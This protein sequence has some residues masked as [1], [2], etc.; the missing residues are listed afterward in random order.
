MNA[1]SAPEHWYNDLIRAKEYVIADFVFKKKIKVRMKW[2]EKEREIEIERE[3]WM[4][5]DRSNN[6]LLSSCR[7]LPVTIV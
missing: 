3:G 6:T 7:R 4:V 5:R 2:K 1:L